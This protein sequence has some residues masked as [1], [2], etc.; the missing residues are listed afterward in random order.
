MAV[1]IEGQELGHGHVRAGWWRVREVHRDRL[2]QMM[3]RRS[4][5]RGHVDLEEI[6]RLEHWRWRRERRGGVDRLGF[7]DHAR[8][9]SRDV[10]RG[11]DAGYEEGKRGGRSRWGH[12]AG[13][14]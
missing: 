5:E 4:I 2:G 14:G 1:R 8:V 7:G 3:D 13:W 12:P 6:L 9:R 10:G 11:R